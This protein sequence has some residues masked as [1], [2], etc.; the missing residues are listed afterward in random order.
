MNS[1]IQQVLFLIGIVFCLVGIF[2]P[3][4]IRGDPILFYTYGIQLSPRLSDNG[5]FE[6]LLL[7]VFLIFGTLM[8]PPP[9]Q[10]AGLGYLMS[11]V[12][13]ILSALYFTGRWFL[14]NITYTGATGAPVIGI[15]LV[16]VLIGSVMLVTI[17]MTKI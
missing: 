11:A 6:F 17:A 14:H 12:L 8:S 1:K 15:G 10:K 3:W 7:T 5:G 4:E 16:L 9:P 2:L 13:L